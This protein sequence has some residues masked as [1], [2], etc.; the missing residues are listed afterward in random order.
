MASASF[1][2]KK[3]SVCFH[4]SSAPLWSV[5]MFIQARNVLLKVVF[6]VYHSRGR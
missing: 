4:L 2:R 5:T 3:E 6:H 1:N